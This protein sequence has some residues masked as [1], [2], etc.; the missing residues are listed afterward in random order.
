MGFQLQD[1]QQVLELYLKLGIAQS[2]NTSEIIGVKYLKID[3]SQNQTTIWNT[4]SKYSRLNTALTMALSCTFPPKC[5]PGMQ[6]SLLPLARDRIYSLSMQSLLWVQA[7]LLLLLSFINKYSPYPG[8]IHGH[9][10]KHFCNRLA[11]EMRHER[12]F[13]ISTGCFP[14][15]YPG[16]N[17]FSCGTPRKTPIKLEIAKKPILTSTA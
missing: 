13:G 14:L 8:L 12:D 17:F 5:N 4:V 15:L 7:A 6:L 11:V 16:A 1:H 3:L 9:Q 2:K 10:R